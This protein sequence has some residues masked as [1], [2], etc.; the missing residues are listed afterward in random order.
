MNVAVFASGGGTNFGAIVTR[1][2][3]E[4]LENTC[5]RV[6]VSN[7]SNCGAVNIA[8]QNAIETVHISNVTH[9][10]PSEYAAAMLNILE[11]RQIGL[12]VLAG[13]MKLLPCVVVSRYP[14][15]I[16]NIHPA[17]LPRFGGTGMYGMNV[18]QAVIDSGVRESGVSVHFVNEE[19]DKGTLI[20]QEK[21]KVHQ[22]DTPE[23]LAARVL[24]KEHDL[25]WRVIDHLIN[26]R[27]NIDRPV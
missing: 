13:Y 19:Y 18:H 6:L 21:V 20:A 3:T 9:P 26:G 7:N 25:Y 10:D 8:K 1:V 5:I 24:E 23:T 2:Q 4:D 16:V 17:L 14:E 15:R 11:A 12:I 22:G 27:P